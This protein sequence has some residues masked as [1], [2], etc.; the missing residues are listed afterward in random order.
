MNMQ[1]VQLKRPAR[2]L[3]VE[4]NPADVKLIKEALGS[5]DIPFTLSHVTNGEAALDYIYQRE[6]F[7]AVL[8]PDLIILDLNLP[9][10][11]WHE[12]LSE[13]KKDEKLKAIPVIILTSSISEA[14]IRKSYELFANTYFVKR[15]DLTEIFAMGEGIGN[16]WLKLCELP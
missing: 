11:K 13:I 9:K 16:Y 3:L 5:A 14:D 2:I 6:P 10:I 8:R 7:K 15:T 12:V 1:A 4:D